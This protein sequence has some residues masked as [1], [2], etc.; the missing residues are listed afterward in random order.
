M[1]TLDKKLRNLIIEFIAH[2]DNSFVGVDEVVAQIKQ[3]FAEEHPIWRLD[4]VTGR[5]DQLMT[6]QEFY[7]RFEK[8]LDSISGATPI[9]NIRQAVKDVARKAAGL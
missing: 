5:S 7:D 4:S 3:V 2:H 8:E 9:T 1:N 6:G